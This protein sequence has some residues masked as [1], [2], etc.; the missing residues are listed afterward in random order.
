MLGGT[1]GT[2]LYVVAANWPGAAALREHTDWDGQVLRTHVSA[3]AAGWPG[4]SS[5]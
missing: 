2:D 1:T 3:P 5:G 4:N